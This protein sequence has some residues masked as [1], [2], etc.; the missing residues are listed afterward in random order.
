[1]MTRGLLAAFN[2]EMASVIAPCSAVL[3]GGAGQQDTTLQ[4][5]HTCFNVYTPGTTKVIIYI[6]N[7]SKPDFTPVH[8]SIDH[9]PSNINISSTWTPIYACANCL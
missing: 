5:K 2:R 1:M 6:K 8:F 3:T 4:Q 9:V 7:T